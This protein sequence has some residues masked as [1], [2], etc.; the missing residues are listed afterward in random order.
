MPEPIVERIAEWLLAALQEITTA[1]GYHYGLKVS[2]N[3]V[4]YGMDETVGDLTVFIEDDEAVEAKKPTLT[5]RFKLQPFMVST[6]LIASAE[7]AVPVDQ[8]KNRIIADIEKR[9]GLE[10]AANPGPDRMCGGLAYWIEVGNAQIWIDRVRQ[11]TVVALPVSISY[12]VL[13]TNPYAQA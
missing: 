4:L 11:A 8:R 5:H 1:G 2:R 13:I 9:L 3:E 6:Y 12:K 7:P 10:I